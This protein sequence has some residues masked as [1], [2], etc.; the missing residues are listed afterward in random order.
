[1]LGVKPAI[2]RDFTAAEDTPAGWQVVMLSDGAWRRKFGADPSIVG[3]AIT[4]SGLPFTIVGVMPASF[5]PLISERFYKPA[6]VWAL[7]GY[8]ATLPHATA[9]LFGLIP[10]IKAS[11]IDLQTSLHGEGRKT[12]HAPTSFARRLLV[13]ADVAMGRGT[14][15]RRRADEQECRPPTASSRGTVSCPGRRADRRCP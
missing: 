3:R 5:E 9:F 15:E 14:A 8:D 10:A 6:E 11:R 2:G 4:L 1:M 13:G 7:F 12:T